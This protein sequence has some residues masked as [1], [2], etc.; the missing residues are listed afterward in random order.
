MKF[1]S[2]GEDRNLSSRRVVE[3]PSQAEAGIGGD[4]VFADS[5]DLFGGTG[6]EAV[7]RDRKHGLDFVL[8]LRYVC[9]RSHYIRPNRLEEVL[10]GFGGLFWFF[11]QYPVAGVFYYYLLYV[12]GYL[13]DLFA[14]GFS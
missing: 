10:Q 1:G 2:E 4:S 5:F 13:S 3:R 14:E 8:C 9:R 11:F 7:Y 6:S 12:C